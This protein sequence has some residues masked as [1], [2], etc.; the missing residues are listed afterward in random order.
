ML[1]EISELDQTY[2]S[3]IERG[4]R[5]LGYRNLVRVAR[6]LGVS[7]SE[8]VAEGERLILSSRRAQ[9]RQARTPRVDKT[10]RKPPTT[11]NSTARMSHWSSA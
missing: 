10:A 7:G 8:L 11:L 2:V 5:N 3:G 9:S 6:A 4:R 1:A